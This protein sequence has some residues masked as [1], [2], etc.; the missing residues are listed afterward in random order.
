MYAKG[1]GVVKDE[2]KAF[3]LMMDSA[4]RDNPPAMINLGDYFQHGIGC[5]R[6]YTT[7]K[8]WYLKAKEKGSDV[9][10]YLSALKLQHK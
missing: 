1:L 3:T 5:Q 4:L 9:T 6:D 8:M 10:E 2:N 7:A